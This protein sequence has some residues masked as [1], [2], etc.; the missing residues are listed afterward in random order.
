MEFLKFLLAPENRYI[1]VISLLILVVAAYMGRRYWSQIT[2]LANELARIQQG[3][4]QSSTAAEPNDADLRNTLD[5]LLQSDKPRLSNAAH[6][7]LRGTRQRLIEWP[8]LPTDPQATPQPKQYALLSSPADLWS[9]RRLLASRLNLGLLDAMPNLLLGVGLAFTFFFLAQS[10]TAATAAL[11]QGATGSSIMDATQGLLQTAGAKFL[12]SLAGLGSS[13]LWTF[14]MRLAMH[15]LEEQ[16]RLVVDG[17]V[18]ATN[19]LGY[20]QLLALQISL[21]QS[22]HATAEQRHT[23]TL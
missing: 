3:V 21:A 20:E 7:A 22:A 9:A 6:D 15:R 5:R 16:S 8:S 1:L 2:K 13:L 10:I 4:R 19:G 17:L 18:G 23:K 14:F 11:G 12:T